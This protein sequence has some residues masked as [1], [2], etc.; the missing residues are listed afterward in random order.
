MEPNIRNPRIM[1]ECGKR[2]RWGIERKREQ[3]RER[4]HDLGRVFVE[5]EIHI[6]C[7]TAIE[8]FNHEIALA[9]EEI[10]FMRD[11]RGMF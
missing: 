7:E 11:G 4:E 6:S 10:H 3:W 2:G 1:P 9:S 8:Y 5:E